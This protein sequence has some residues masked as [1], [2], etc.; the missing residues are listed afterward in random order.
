[1]NS[2]ESILGLGSTHKMVIAQELVSFL[3]KEN[4]DT[5]TLGRMSFSY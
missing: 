2:W 5:T 3:Y 4:C 1:M